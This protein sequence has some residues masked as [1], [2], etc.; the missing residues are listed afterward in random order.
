MEDASSQRENGATH[1]LEMMA[2]RRPNLSA[3]APAQ[4]KGQLAIT[5]CSKF[6]IAAVVA[7]AV[8]VIEI[9]R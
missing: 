8:T 9:D 6:V 3:I 4:K 5:S 1:V 7:V 2:D